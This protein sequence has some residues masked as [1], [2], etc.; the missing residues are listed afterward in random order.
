[1]Q[2]KWNQDYKLGY[3][4]IINVNLQQFWNWTDNTEATF[5]PVTDLFL[6]IEETIISSFE[7][8]SWIPQGSDF[9]S[10]LGQYIE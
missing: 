2:N 5:Y 7:F 9:L 10:I 4:K 8:G 1:M 6:N 3:F